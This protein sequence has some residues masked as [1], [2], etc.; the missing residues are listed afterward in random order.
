MSA[1]QRRSRLRMLMRLYTLGAAAATMGG[2][3]LTMFSRSLGMP[4]SVLPLTVTATVGIALYAL[5]A[6]FAVSDE[7]NLELLSF[8]VAIGHVFGAI[9]AVAVLT[10]TNTDGQITIGSLVVSVR[11]VLFGFLLVDSFVSVVVLWQLKAI[12]R[13]SLA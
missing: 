1:T 10:V 5:V 9:M 7:R 13:A 6:L 8:L 2:W 4:S 12:K 11:H 3:F